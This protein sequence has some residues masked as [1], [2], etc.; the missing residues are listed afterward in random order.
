[1]HDTFISYATEDE[2]FA[3][4][5]AGALMARG[6][7]IWYAPLKLKVGDRLLVGIEEGLRF[8]RSGTIIV[9]K[10]FLAKKWTHYELDILVRQAIES[11]KPLLQIWH[12]VSKSDVETRYMGLTG[13]LALE[14]R[15]GLPSIINKIATALAEFS[16]LRGAVRP[17]EDAV[18][19]FLEGTAQIQLCSAG[20]QA[21]SLFQVLL[22]YEPSD[23]PLFLEGRQYSRVELVDYAE[24]ALEQGSQQV[25]KWIS[26][27]KELARLRTVIRTAKLSDTAD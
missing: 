23:F 14:S 10:A 5:L 21:L 11:G 2:R 17:W 8:S 7:S 24:R 9:S 1:M 13:M 27:K 4:E 16:P 20:N 26:S 12:G 19:R 6:I 25:M 18:H 3:G 22:A 15:Y